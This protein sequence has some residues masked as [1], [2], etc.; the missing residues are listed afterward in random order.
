ML[1]KLMSD[2]KRKMI[3]K[4]MLKNWNNL[5]VFTF[6]SQKR[7]TRETKFPSQTF[8]RSC[9]ILLRKYYPT[10][11]MWYEKLAP[12]KRKSCTARGNVNSH[13][14]SQYQTH[15]SD[16]A[17]GNQTQKLSLNM[18][19][20]TP[21]HGSVNMASQY[22]IAIAIIWSYPIHPKSQYDSN[23]QSTKQGVLQ[24]PYRR[25]PQRFSPT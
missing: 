2:T 17:N 9:H 14:V 12:K 13:P 5:I 25:T 10:I 8:G 23:K 3:K 19:I 22:L 11:I 24:E 7:T 6:C 18:M 20:Y 21:E 15:Q 4:P 16:H 1:C